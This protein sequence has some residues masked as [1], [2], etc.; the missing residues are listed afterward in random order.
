MMFTGT[1]KSPVTVI[2]VILIPIMG[3]SFYTSISGIVKAKL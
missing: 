1:V 2:F 3:L